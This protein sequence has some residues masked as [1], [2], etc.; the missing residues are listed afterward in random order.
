MLQIQQSDPTCFKNIKVLD[1]KQAKTNY[2]QP[3]PP[4]HPINHTKTC[5]KNTV[6]AQYCESLQPSMYSLPRFSQIQYKDTV[7]HSISIQKKHQPRG[8]TQEPCCTKLTNTQTLNSTKSQHTQRPR[9]QPS[10]MMRAKSTEGSVFHNGSTLSL[11]DQL[12]RDF[13]SSLI[14]QVRNILSFL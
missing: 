12:T 8:K 3:F 1:R 5:S 9:A 2:I 6:K 11:N 13:P 10:S 14:I 4:T 7:T